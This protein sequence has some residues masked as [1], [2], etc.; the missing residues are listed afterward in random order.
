MLASKT[1]L[2]FLKPMV[3]LMTGLNDLKFASELESGDAKTILNRIMKKVQKIL[4]CDASLP[5]GGISED[6]C[7]P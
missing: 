7:P 3:K 1:S 5:N 4:P 2:V 6:L